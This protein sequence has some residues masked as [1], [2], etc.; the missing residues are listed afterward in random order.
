MNKLFSHVGAAV[1]KWVTVLLDRWKLCSGDVELLL[2]LMF[3]QK[4][5][6][7]LSISSLAFSG[8]SKRVYGRNYRAPKKQAHELDNGLVPLPAKV[9]FTCTKCVLCH[10]LCHFL[11]NRGT[12][13]FSA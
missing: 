3:V 4:L 9:C 10:T 6:H 8:S 2:Q 7:S 1:T 12:F 13:E 5:P 11:S